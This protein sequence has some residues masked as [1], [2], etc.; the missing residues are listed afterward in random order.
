MNRRFSQRSRG[1]SHNGRKSTAGLRLK[2]L[3]V[4]K[5]CMNQWIE[6]AALAVG[7]FVLGGP[8]AWSADTTPA[9]QLQHWQTQAGQAGD[10]A[11]GQVFFNASHG[12]R[13]SCASCHG[14]HP[15]GEG[16][17]ATTGKAIAPLAPAFNARALTDEAKVNKW[18]KRNCSD[19]LAREC[20]AS[21]KADVLA[22]LIGLKPTGVRP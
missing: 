11:R 3:A 14:P 19:V 18:F 22:Y 8:A 15:T 7:L 2:G 5:G 13:W 20:S 6:K 10:A 9:L 4:K 16:K 21:E 17:H 1:H 12:G